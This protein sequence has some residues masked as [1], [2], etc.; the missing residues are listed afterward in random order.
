MTHAI[1]RGV[2][3]MHVPLV[4]LGNEYFQKISCTQCVDLK[5]PQINLVL[6]FLKSPMIVWNTQLLN[7][8]SSSGFGVSLRPGHLQ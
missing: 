7:T 1:L 3:G 2:G 5:N 4:K 6:V 8:L